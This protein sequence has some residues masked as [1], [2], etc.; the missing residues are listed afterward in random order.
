MKYDG[1]IIQDDLDDIEQREM[2][3][4]VLPEENNWGFSVVPVY[5]LENE[6]YST[7]A[8]FFSFE[9]EGW[10]TNFFDGTR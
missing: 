3:F 5:R 2:K 6:I 4:F 9:T 1:R 7:D 10:L 8:E